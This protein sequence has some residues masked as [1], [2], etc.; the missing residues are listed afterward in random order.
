MSKTN[1]IGST[2]RN[3]LDVSIEEKRRFINSFDHIL[4]DC[5]GKSTLCVEFY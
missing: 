5:D 3:L 1:I 4:T 2:V